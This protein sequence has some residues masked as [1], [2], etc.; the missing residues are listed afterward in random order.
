[1]SIKALSKEDK[2]KRWSSAIAQGMACKLK[3]PCL[4]N[5]PSVSVQLPK[6]TGH[7]QTVFRDVFQMC[8]KS[9]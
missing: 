1:M 3:Q 2:A 8:E 6:R 9:L 4:L 5:F 7:G